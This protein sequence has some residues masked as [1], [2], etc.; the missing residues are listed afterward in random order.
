M[1]GILSPV[2]QTQIGKHGER[3]LRRLKREQVMHEER[4]QTEMGR[5]ADEEELI[6]P[7]E[8]LHRSDPSK[9]AK[10]DNKGNRQRES[11]PAAIHDKHFDKPSKPMKQKAGLKRTNWARDPQLREAV[12]E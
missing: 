11:R 8:P 1:A 10:A 5:T 6:F 7:S 12:E 4:L 3:V 2:K 9:Q